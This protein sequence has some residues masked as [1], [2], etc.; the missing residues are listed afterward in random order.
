MAEAL[1]KPQLVQAGVSV[2]SAGLAALVG[3]PADPHAIALM[4]ERGIDIRGHR[5][6][7]VTEEMLKRA[8]LILTMDAEQQQTVVTAWPATR[9]RV[10]ALGRW[11]GIEVADPYQLGEQAFKTALAAIESG[12]ADWQ[13]W[14]KTGTA[15][16]SLFFT[17]IRFFKAG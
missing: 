2:A 12:T 3:A 17:W 15:P 9:G 7:Q 1:F 11:S 4:A 10:H 8:S 13:H 6:R 14:L 16:K 5:A